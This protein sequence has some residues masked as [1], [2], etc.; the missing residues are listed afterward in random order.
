MS[1]KKII[2]GLIISMFIGLFGVGVYADDLTA[3]IST[4]YFG[5][6]FFDGFEKSFDVTVSNN[7]NEAMSLDL[8]YHISDSS[9]GVEK[10]TDS[11]KLAIGAMET[12][13]EKYSLNSELDY[14]VYT[15]RIIGKSN[16]QEVLNEETEFSVCIKVPKSKRNAKM[17]IN[18]HLNWGDGRNIPAELGI[19]NNIGISSIREG[20]SWAAFEKVRG[21]Y[22]QTQAC[23]DYLTNAAVYGNDVLVM[24]GFSNLLYSSDTNSFPSTDSERTAFASYVYNMLARGKN[25]D[26]IKCVELW[27]EPDLQTRYAS[28]E[29]YA[30]LLKTVYERIKPDFPNV[31]IGAPALGKTLGGDDESGREWLKAFLNTDLDGDGMFDTYK[32]FDIVCLHQYDKR[33]DVV[34]NRLHRVNDILNEY[35]CSDKDVY[36]TEFGNSRHTSDVIEDEQ[37][38]AQRLVRYYLTMLS[39]NISD[40]Y[41][42]YDFSNDGEDISD[43]E[44]TFGL[45]QSHKAEIPCA[46]KPGLLAVAAMN[47]FTGGMNVTDTSLSDGYRKVIMMNDGQGNS[48]CAMFLNYTDKLGQTLNT[49]YSETYEFVTDSTNVRFFD[50]LGNRIY[51]QATSDGYVVEIG[52]APIYAAI[53]DKYPGQAELE[54]VNIQRYGKSVHV[55]GQILNAENDE[56]IGIRIFDEER[57]PVYIDQLKTADGKFEVVFYPK[58]DGIFTIN[59]GVKSLGKMVSRQFEYESVCAA[60]TKVFD[61]SE[62]VVTFS[63]YDNNGTKDLQVKIH[64]RLCGSF[65]VFMGYFKDNMLI[66]TEVINSENMVLDGDVYHYTLKENIP[67]D[68]DSVRIMTVDS[69]NSLT[70]LCRYKMFN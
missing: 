65:V 6:I 25:S 46:A 1:F 59:I 36:Q 7:T 43:F 68:A 26:V 64:D 3:D 16:G 40:R 37:V 57:N 35:G 34:I 67:V 44:N 52:N 69:V 47:Y 70:P 5:N 20:Y 61:N 62:E 54:Y 14:G 12:Y 18:A 50:Y 17:G 30:K 28:P 51:P 39:E 49:T 66:N 9:D 53:S 55:F 29:E 58:K 38:Q 15:L 24:A 60:V 11:K 22:S 33:Y 10:L 21:N 8:E 31:K 41:Y 48:L 32:Y 42:I 56:E 45:C 23:T 63:E 13:S 27:N 4:S 2:F 19:I